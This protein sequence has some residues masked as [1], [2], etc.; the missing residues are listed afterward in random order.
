MIITPMVAALIASCGFDARAELSEAEAREYVKR[1]VLVIDVRT[2]EEFK[3]KSLTNVVN[4]PLAEVNPAPKETS[5]ALQRKNALV[6]ARL[7]LDRIDACPEDT[8]NRII[9]HA[10]KGSSTPYP[11]WA[12]KLVAD[13]DDD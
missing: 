4:I 2:V 1:G 8:L 7:P 10:M 11:M 9:W 3:A 13:E 6:S 12:V 5:D